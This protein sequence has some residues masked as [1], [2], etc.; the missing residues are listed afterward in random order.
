MNQD[1][2]NLKKHLSKMLKIANFIRNYG[3]MK[4][5]KKKIKMKNYQRYFYF[6]KLKKKKK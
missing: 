4:M 6:K 3:K 1:L 2:K 5:K